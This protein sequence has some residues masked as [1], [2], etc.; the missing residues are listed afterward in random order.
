MNN[1]RV[2]KILP[3]VST[4]LILLVFFL[5]WEAFVRAFEV[6]PLVLPAAAGRAGQL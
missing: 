5:A 2:R 4:P 6:S 3:W 1:D